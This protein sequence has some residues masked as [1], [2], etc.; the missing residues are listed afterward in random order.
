MINP[1]DVLRVFFP[2]LLGL[3]LGYILRREKKR[4]NLD[5]LIFWVILLLVFSLG[6]AVG[7]NNELL[8]VM[9]DAGLKAL[10]LSALTLIFTILFVK[11]LDKTVRA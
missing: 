11:A 8:A 10:V 2:L 5:R 9:P 1:F 6:F 7:S 4:L 3:A